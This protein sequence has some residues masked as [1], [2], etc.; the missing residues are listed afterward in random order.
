MKGIGVDMNLFKKMTIQLVLYGILLMSPLTIH[1]SLLSNDN[2]CLAAENTEAI[3]HFVNGQKHYEKAYELYTL[4]ERIDEWKKAITEFTKAIQLNPNYAMA[5]YARS[6]T[7]QELGDS[8]SAM[9]DINVAIN[10]HSNDARY[11][12]WRGLMYLENVNILNYEKA[13][14]DFTKSIEL[15]PSNV[16]AYTQR[17]YAYHKLNK[18]QLAIND[19]NKA[20]ELNPLEAEAYRNRGIVYKD[21][22]NY[23]QAL[24]DL[25]KAIELNAD[26]LTSYIERSEVYTELNKEYLRQYGKS[27]IEYE[28]RSKEDMNKYREIQRKIF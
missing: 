12:L 17:G 2:Y 23:Q 1:S 15:L 27:N 24:S 3:N 28:R 18:L 22:K 5:Y 4:K 21:L 10:I 6:L 16:E 20:I 8:N 26:D 13:V 14:I 11:Y 7:Y 19:L 25:S 9:N